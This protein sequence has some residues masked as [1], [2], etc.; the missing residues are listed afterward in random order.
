MITKKATRKS[1]LSPKIQMYAF[2]EIGVIS[3]TG[4]GEPLDLEG[5]DNKGFDIIWED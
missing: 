4:S 3:T 2:D 5:Y 1:Y